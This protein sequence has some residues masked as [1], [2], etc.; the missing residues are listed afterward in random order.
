MLLLIV[1]RD[2]ACSFANRLQK[3]DKTKLYQ[4]IVV[5]I[6]TRPRIKIEAHFSSHHEHVS[7]IQVVI[8]H[9]ASQPVRERVS[10]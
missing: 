3:V 8:L 1:S 4:L 2:M 7:K 6:S 9:K 10:E 5:E